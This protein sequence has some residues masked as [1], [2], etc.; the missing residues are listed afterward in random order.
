MASLDNFFPISA[1]C[2]AT[3]PPPSLPPLRLALLL[4]PGCMPAG[5]FAT[6][7]LARAANLRA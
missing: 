6:A 5:L 1:T 3:M 4:Y 7:D 2:T